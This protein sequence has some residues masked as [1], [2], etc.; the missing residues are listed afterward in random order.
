MGLGLGLEHTGHN[1]MLIINQM[2]PLY[3][4]GYADL[5]LINKYWW[6]RNLDSNW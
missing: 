4:Q 5:Y 3:W 6:K 1:H 2:L